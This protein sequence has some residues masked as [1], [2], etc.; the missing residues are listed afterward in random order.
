MLIPLEVYIDF[1]C[2]WCYIVKRSLDSAMAKFIE[3]HPEVEFELSWRPFYVA[4]MLKT[5]K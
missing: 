5:C 1:I 2:P 4:P 3:R